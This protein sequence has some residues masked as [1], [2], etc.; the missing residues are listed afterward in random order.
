[1]FFSGDLE[2]E[3]SL[4]LGNMIPQPGRVYIEDA[5]GDGLSVFIGL[6]LSGGRVSTTAGARVPLQVCVEGCNDKDAQAPA[7][8]LQFTGELSF[9]LSPTETTIGGKLSMM[10]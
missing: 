9:G 5:A 3:Y 6:K 8:F 7:R 2:L 4:K 10:G 1:M